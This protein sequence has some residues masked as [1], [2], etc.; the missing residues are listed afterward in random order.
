MVKSCFLLIMLVVVTAG[1][2]FADRLP[3]NQEAVP[4]P[5]GN[6][7]RTVQL[8]LN[9]DADLLIESSEGKRVG[10]DFKSRKFVN[11]I[12]EAR[13]ISNESSST[14][15]LPFD[16]SGKPYQVTVSGK[17]ATKVVADLSMTGPGFVVGFRG[18]PLTAG[19]LQK[20]TIASNGSHLSLTANQDG[21]TP[22]LFITAQSGR[23][24]PS[25]RF[26]V[27]S[28][29]LKTGKT[30]TV[31]LDTEK[32]RLYFKT[33]DPK[34]DSF[35]AKMRRTNPTGTR[36]M[37]AHQDISFGGINSYAMDFGQWDGQGE[38]CFFEVCN[39]CQEKPC[40]K[41]KNESGAR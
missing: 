39:S 3:N 36:D 32:G 30:I 23:G 11:E 19:Q 33:D 29:L 18:V 20:L 13:V 28:S 21:P 1:F 2:D 4:T 27:A 6:I 8:S 10:L 40:T 31:D 17:S 14:V 26:E 38:V 15:L 5:A 25:Y 35:S 22:L 12:P 24:K 7:A 9:A 37:F 34:K 16:K 41:L